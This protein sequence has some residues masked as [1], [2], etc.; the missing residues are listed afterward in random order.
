[1]LKSP[2][3]PVYNSYPPPSPPLISTPFSLIS[4]ISPRPIIFSL[5]C[6]TLT[7]TNQTFALTKK[8]W[9]CVLVAF[10]HLF[11]FNH[12]QNHRAIDHFRT[13]KELGRCQR[14]LYW[15]C[16]QLPTFTTLTG[17]F[18]LARSDNEKNWVKRG[19]DLALNVTVEVTH[20]RGNGCREIVSIAMATELGHTRKLLDLP[21]HTSTPWLDS[22][23]KRKIQSE[24]RRCP[25]DTF[26]E[27][28]KWWI[29]LRIHLKGMLW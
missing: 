22:A 1:M 13:P 25:L 20:N 5:L 8:P 16:K 4:T 21:D 24:T 14:L 28:S 11:C 19:V 7:R 27:M 10:Q 18:L 6:T 3:F 12:E 2:Q 15:L 29:E 9:L 17:E 26:Q 23:Q